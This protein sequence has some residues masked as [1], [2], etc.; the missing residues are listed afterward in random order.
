MVYSKAETPEEYLAQLPSNRRK[1]IST[2]RGIILKSLPKGYKERTLWGMICYVIPLERYPGTYNNQP[3]CL[4]A[5]ASQK[6]YMSLY[7]MNVYGNKGLEKWFKD[8]WKKSGKKLNMGK[9]CV[10]FKSL[11][12]LPLNLIAQVISKTPV[13]TYIS[14]YESSRIK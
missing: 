10:R 5:L 3:L 2:L 6:N 4:A 13:D 14:I 9:S 7:L 8:E 1:A 12:D 11:N